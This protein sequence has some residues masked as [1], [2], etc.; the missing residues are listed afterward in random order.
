MTFEE[1]D[2]DLLV[3]GGGSAGTMAAIRAKELNPD[4]DVTIVEK[5]HV[6][7][8]GSITMGMDALNVMVI[9][10]KA[11]PRDYAEV[12]RETCQGIADFRPSFTL[13][14]RSFALLKKLE[15]WGVFFPKDNS[16]DYQ[17]MR[18]HPRGNFCVAMDEPDLKVMLWKRVDENGVHI[19]NRT[20]AISLLSED[21]SVKG[22]VCLDLNRRI[23]LVIHARATVLANGGAGRFG[24]PASGYLYGTWDYPGNAGDGYS[25][26]FHAGA[27]LT[28][29]E[30][31]VTNTLIKDVH[32]PLLYITLTRGARL[33]NALGE[34]IAEGD[35]SPSVESRVEQ[36][37]LAGPLF[38]RMDHLPEEK[39]QEIEH[40]LFT[41]ERPIQRRYWQ[42]RKINFRTHPI[43]LAL[44]EPQLC[45]GHGISGLVVNDKSE[46]SVRGLYVAGDVAAVPTQHL[47][48]AF[49]FGQ[50]AA[51]SALGYMDNRIFA[52]CR[53]ERPVDAVIA[54]MAGFLDNSRAQTSLANFEY[55]VRRSINEYVASP[56]N[57]YKLNRA[58]E[59][60]QQFHQELPRL[61]RVDSPH[62][63][64]RALEVRSIIEC[65]FF[66]AAAA[67]A[68]QESRWGDRHKRIDFPGRDDENWLKHIDISKDAAFPSLQVSFRAV[69]QETE[70]C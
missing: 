4:C 31:V 70:G 51:E 58:K 62:E 59:L 27:K 6:K 14:A 22:A 24:L 53:A 13:A 69:E 56:K 30:Y 67:D 19:F 5:A 16:G 54:D 26:G 34:I 66:S 46:T 37:R 18:I 65:A 28:G 29:L 39:I 42:Q 48:G 32:L 68:R 49:V 8:S 1:F 43:E 21:G 52:K 44:T 40:V 3:I 60:M 38:V 2:T 41:T 45:G 7:R 25:L 63:L 23:L 33:V 50:I 9:P 10:G 47:T 15:S 17:T 12:C 55:K 57:H 61:A 20:M 64:G 35:S 11:T 36:F